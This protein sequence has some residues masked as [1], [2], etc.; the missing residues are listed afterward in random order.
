M[1]YV[2]LSCLMFA[3]SEE[4]LHAMVKTI[5]LGSHACAE[6]R[7]CRF[8]VH[9]PYPGVDVPFYRLTVKQ[10]LR[11]L[12]HGAQQGLRLDILR[13]LGVLSP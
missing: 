1:V 12:R 7:R 2:D 4:E 11:A 6:V 3:D 9:L 10:A 5:V 13:Q 8:H